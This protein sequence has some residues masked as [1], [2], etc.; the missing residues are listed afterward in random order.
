MT[1]IRNYREVWARLV[2]ALRWCGSSDYTSITYTLIDA[3]ERD[4]FCEAGWCPRPP[5]KHLIDGPLGCFL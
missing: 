5:L 1:D 4:L 3:E 2:A